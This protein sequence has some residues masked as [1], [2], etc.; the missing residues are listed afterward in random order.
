M[1]QSA[2]MKF[3]Y[4]QLWSKLTLPK[5]ERELEGVLKLL[6]EGLCPRNGSAARQRTSNRPP[7]DLQ[8][9]ANRGYAESA[10]RKPLAAAPLRSALRAP[11][12]SAAYTDQD[13]W[14]ISIAS[15]PRSTPSIR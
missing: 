1:I 6:I 9:A 5:L 15:A 8:F 4:P 10:M 14:P 3:R 12:V 7:P 2:T 13:S 11:G